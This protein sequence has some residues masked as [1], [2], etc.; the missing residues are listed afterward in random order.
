MLDSK[1]EHMTGLN[2]P[3]TIRFEGTVKLGGGMAQIGVEV[4]PE[5]ILA[6]AEA[7]KHNAHVGHAVWH[8]NNPGR[9]MPCSSC[10]KEEQPA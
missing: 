6:L 7:L 3:N 8:V 2:W 9:E 4:P 5:T 1:M 10:S